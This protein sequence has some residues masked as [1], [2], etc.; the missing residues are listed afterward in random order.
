M[1]KLRAVPANKKAQKK[2]KQKARNKKRQV[3][4]S[5]RVT[6]QSLIDLSEIS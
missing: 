6:D 2:N 5:K 4:K 1:T 3:K